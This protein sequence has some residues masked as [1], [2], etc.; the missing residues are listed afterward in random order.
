[1]HFYMVYSHTKHHF[2]SPSCTLLWEWL[3]F[4]SDEP[5]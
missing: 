1:M 2:Y 3:N 5:V 4:L